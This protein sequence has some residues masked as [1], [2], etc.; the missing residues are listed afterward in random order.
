LCH[1]YITLHKD[2]SGV[3][4][5]KLWG[6][7]WT[8]CNVICSGSRTYLLLQLDKMKQQFKK[9]LLHHSG[10]EIKII[11]GWWDHEDSRNTMFWEA[12]AT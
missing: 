8:K 9:V 11:Y 2:K 1:L 7:K 10:Y 3:L 5:G 4:Q 12:I 6:N